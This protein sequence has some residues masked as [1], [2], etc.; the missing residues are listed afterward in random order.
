M[1]IKKIAILGF[2]ALLLII[3]CGEKEKIED[4]IVQETKI[5]NEA[6]KDTTPTFN[7]K[8]TTGKTIS[9][10]ANKEG[11]KFKG[12]ED[13]VV[14]L[15]FFGTWCPPC[16]AEIPHLNNIKSKLKKDFEILAIDIGS[17]SGGFNTQEHLKS[18]VNKYNITYPIVSGQSAKQLFSVV[19]ELNPSG[20]IPFMVLFNKKGQYVKYYIGMK[21]EE[22]LFNDISATIKMK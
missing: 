8:T 17:R 15:N 20:S 1:K 22:M 6:K 21:P 2:L 3:G 13:K 18:F 10:I 5:A 14:L 16:K 11:W 4:S 12:L 19:S 7:L 9:I